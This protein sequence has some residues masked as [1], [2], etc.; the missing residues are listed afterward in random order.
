[1][2]DLLAFRNVDVAYILSSVF[3]AMVDLRYSEY[4]SEHAVDRVEKIVH[5]GST[6]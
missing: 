3:V 1:M 2:H 5:H 4:G 6:A